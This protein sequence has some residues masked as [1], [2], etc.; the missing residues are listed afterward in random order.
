MALSRQPRPP[1]G[2]GDKAP[3]STAA[4]PQPW[5]TAPRPPLCPGVQ[6]RPRWCR[7]EAGRGAGA[8]RA[9]PPWDRSRLSLHPWHPWPSPALTTAAQGPLPTAVPRQTRNEVAEG[10]LAARPLHGGLHALFLSPC[11]T[12]RAHGHHT[13]HVMT[14]SE[15]TAPAVSHAAELYPQQ[16]QPGA[17]GGAAPGS[18]SVR[19]PAQEGTATPL[20]VQV[21]GSR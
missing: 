6:A 11:W 16:R 3:L 18:A 1:S 10:R 13:G 9:V 21:A 5:G 7:G 15:G 17:T 2:L 12:L 8:Y 19:P 4:S 20:S 14:S